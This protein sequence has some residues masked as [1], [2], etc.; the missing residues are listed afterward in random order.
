MAIMFFDEPPE[1]IWDR[2][3]PDEGQNVFDEPPEEIWDRLK[4]DEGPIVFDELPEEIRIKIW[5]RLDFETVQKTCTLVSH[6]WLATIRN[7]G[8]LSGQLALNLEK[9]VIAEQCNPF[10][11]YDDVRHDDLPSTRL[12]MGIIFGWKQLQTLRTPRLIPYYLNAISSLKKVIFGKRLDKNLVE[13]KNLS[14]IY[15]SKIYY[16][17]H[18]KSSRVERILR[19]PNMFEVACARMGF[20]GTPR[21]IS[22]SSEQRIRKE[23]GQS[24]FPEIAIQLTILLFEP[25]EKDYTIDQSLEEIVKKMENLESLYIDVRENFSGRFDY[26]I[27]ALRGLKSCPKLKELVVNI[28]REIQ[29]YSQLFSFLEALNETYFTRFTSLKIQGQGHD[30][31]DMSDL[32]WIVQ[33]KNLEELSCEFEKEVD[34]LG[35]F[36]SYEMFYANPMMKLKHLKIKLF[37]GFVYG[38]GGPPEILIN[39][40]KA[41]PNLESFTYIGNG[42]FLDHGWT[43]DTLISV[44]ESLGKVNTLHISK[45]CYQLEESEEDENPEVVFD[46]ALEIINKKFPKNSTDLKIKTQAKSLHLSRAVRYL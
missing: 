6:E 44:L 22:K 42:E 23:D 36:D 11:R 5:K 33:F 2:L 16:D 10:G 43:I 15:L 9:M 18:E 46:A 19:R 30:F 3:K 26:C 40:H 31:I 7:S 45:V 34:C 8:E 21:N 12:T 37:E 35:D 27:P 29:N 4:P 17:P 41:F 38:F 14:W 25:V 13:L 20:G 32:N 24:F 39:L 28:D 1:E